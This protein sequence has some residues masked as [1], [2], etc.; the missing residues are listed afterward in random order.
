MPSAQ[1]HQAT[2]PEAAYVPR[3]NAERWDVRLA[4]TVL[5]TRTHYADIDN[6]LVAPDGFS[7]GPHQG[8]VLVQWTQDHNFAV[9]RRPGRR[10]RWDA[11]LDQI[12][13]ALEDA[14][15]TGLRRTVKSVQARAPLS[16]TAQTIARVHPTDA[17]W[18][19]TDTVCFEGYDRKTVGGLVGLLDNCGS[20]SVLFATDAQG[21]QVGSGYRD[22]PHAVHGLAHHYGLPMPLLIVQERDEDR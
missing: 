5:T 3:P 11:A 12:E 17:P 19:F 13:E 4:R 22:R 2:A 10:R 9:P 6:Q 20:R 8:D 14:G 18:K 16:A 1:P 15:F 7:I 21:T